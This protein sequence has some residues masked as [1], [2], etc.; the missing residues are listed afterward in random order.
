MQWTPAVNHSWGA[1]SAHGQAAPFLV[2]RQPH[3]FCLCPLNA[4]H[5]LLILYH[6]FFNT[7]PSSLSSCCSTAGV[8]PRHFISPLLCLSEVTHDALVPESTTRKEDYWRKGTCWGNRAG[9]QGRQMGNERLSSKEIK[10]KEARVE[11]DGTRSD[12]NQK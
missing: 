10:W 4:K 6:F 1:A 12:E 2:W 11:R 8:F 7:S 3:Q 5:T 9:D